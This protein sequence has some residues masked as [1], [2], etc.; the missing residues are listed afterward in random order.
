MTR[1]MP[2][3]LALAALTGL[4]LLAAAALPLS[5]DEAYYWTWSHAL[6]PGY[7]DHPPMVALWMRA[8]AWLAGD[9]ALGLR[10]LGPLAAAAG[11]ALL[12]DMADAVRPGAGLP[13]AALFNGTLLLGPGRSR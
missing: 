5:G 10:L 12:A 1:P 7:L 13:A 9:G 11:S 2:W 3:L 6:Q 8:G 4:R